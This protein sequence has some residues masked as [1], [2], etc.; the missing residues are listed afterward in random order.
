VP[1]PTLAAV[2]EA[3]AAGALALGLRH[4]PVHAECRVADDG[5]YLLEV[6]A[7]PIGGLCANALTFTG[8]GGAVASFEE[9]LLRHAGGEAVAPWEREARASGVMM[10]PIP[11]AGVYR[12]VQHVEAAARVPGV[13]SVHV[14]AKQG[15]RLVPLPEGASYL[16]FI[17]ARAE[18][19]AEVE[20]ALRGAHGLLRFEIDA[21][22]ALAG[23]V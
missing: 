3:V 22:V 20:N 17:F 19:P 15:Q 8:P 11:Y 18:T 10:I 13:T 23:T 5:V 1:P 6:A 16:G 21:R 9:L 12:G 2:S 4:G 14:S 7:R